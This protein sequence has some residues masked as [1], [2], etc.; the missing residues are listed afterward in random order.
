MRSI[1]GRAWILHLFSIK[2]LLLQEMGFFINNDI[3]LCEKLQPVYCQNKTETVREGWGTEL[4]DW[5]KKEL[6]P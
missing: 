6:K 2:R 4:R 1:L 5:Q 3:Y